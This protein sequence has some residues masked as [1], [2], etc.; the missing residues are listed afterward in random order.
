MEKA[1]KL[2]AA[3]RH[4]EDA[5]LAL[6]ESA[7]QAILAVNAD[8]RIV[9]ANETADEMFGYSPN[10]LSSKKRGELAKL[11]NQLNRLKAIPDSAPQPQ[12]P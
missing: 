5:L 11:Q 3:L 10:E 6:L 9:L 7:A 8:G 12:M 2:A 4:R 1:R